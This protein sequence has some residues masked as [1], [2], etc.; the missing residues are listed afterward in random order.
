VFL[1][2][3][4]CTVTEAT[5]LA[6][7]SFYETVT[8][9]R[10]GQILFMLKHHIAKAVAAHAPGLTSWTGLPSP[11]N[12]E[13]APRDV[14]SIVRAW[15]A[16]K[17]RVELLVADA[18]LEVARYNAGAGLLRV[19][20]PLLRDKCTSRFGTELK[21]DEF[22]PMDWMHFC[23]ANHRDKAVFEKLLLQ[24]QADVGPEEDKLPSLAVAQATAV[25]Q[26]MHLLGCFVGVLHTHD[27]VFV[28]PTIPPCGFE[29]VG[30]LSAQAK[31]EGWPAV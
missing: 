19:A 14:G 11:F 1:L 17:H 3:A 28:A 12:L 25:A 6:A 13:D 2:V 18:S 9:S 5:S 27:G 29:S 16:L 4:T 26:Y 30:D 21:F 15:H 20:E 31:K 7:L 23:Q 22:R 10:N 24:L 8:R